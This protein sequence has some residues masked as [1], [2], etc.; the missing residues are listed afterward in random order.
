MNKNDKLLDWYGLSK[1]N[2][3]SEIVLPYKNSHNGGRDPVTDPGTVPTIPEPSQMMLTLLGIFVL[4]F[5]RDRNH[6]KKTKTK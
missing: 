1:D 3:R 2:R 5:R 6:A 4:V